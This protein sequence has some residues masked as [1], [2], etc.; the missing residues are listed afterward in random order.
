MN[1]IM[2]YYYTE[3]A[4]GRTIVDCFTV[5]TFACAF[6]KRSTKTSC[7]TPEGSPNSLIFM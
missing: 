1:I 2:Y 5:N 4:C 7:A 6:K 3:K